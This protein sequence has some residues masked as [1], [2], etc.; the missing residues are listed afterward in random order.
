MTSGAMTS[1]AV[2]SIVATSL[3]IVGALVDPLNPTFADSQTATETPGKVP[4]HAD[5]V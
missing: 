5:P 4:G 3:A 2:T 1:G